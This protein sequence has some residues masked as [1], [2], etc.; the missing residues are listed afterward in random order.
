ME[1]ISL[2]CP[3]FGKAR[4]TNQ[5]DAAAG[6]EEWNL[7]LNCQLNKPHQEIKRQHLW[8]CGCG[9][10]RVLDIAGHLPEHQ[11]KTVALGEESSR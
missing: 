2:V 5:G 1:N 6:K 3:W 8:G 11:Q 9:T 10:A 7:K 4:I